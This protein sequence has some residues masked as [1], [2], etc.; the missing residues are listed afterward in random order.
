MVGVLSICRVSVYRNVL[1]SLPR[2][3][4][5]PL[6]M[7]AY[8]NHKNVHRYSFPQKTT[9]L[10]LEK[11]LFLCVNVLWWYVSLSLSLSAALP[12]F[13][14]KISSSNLYLPWEWPTNGEMVV[15][16]AAMMVVVMCRAIEREGWEKDG[17]ASMMVLVVAV[18]MVVVADGGWLAAWFVG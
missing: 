10:L 12:A 13:G 16:A 11:Q 8:P 6:C 17:S 5:A 9:T 1:L 3:I 7:C 4:T 15:A 2:F 18:V 14:F